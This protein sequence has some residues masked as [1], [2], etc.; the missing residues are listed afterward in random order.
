[1]AHI[2]IVVTPVTHKTVLGAKFYPVSML[3]TFS[4]SEIEIYHLTVFFQISNLFL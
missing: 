3:I 1:M 2:L 4:E